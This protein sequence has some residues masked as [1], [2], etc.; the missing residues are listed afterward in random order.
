MPPGA[1][2]RRRRGQALQIRPQ[3][4]GQTHIWEG[5]S[6]EPPIVSFVPP[7]TKNLHEAGFPLS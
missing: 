5:I 7:G 4:F 3:G 1:A 2:R 6:R